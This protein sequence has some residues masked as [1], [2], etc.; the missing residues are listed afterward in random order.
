[1]W[2]SEKNF[3]FVTIMKILIRS[4][5]KGKVKFI[6]G[7]GHFLNEVFAGAMDDN[8]ARNEYI[9]VI[10]AVII[11]IFGKSIPIVLSTEG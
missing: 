9:D 3:E 1:M 6:A 7:Q 4:I 8:M 2:I 11:G 5:W 10:R